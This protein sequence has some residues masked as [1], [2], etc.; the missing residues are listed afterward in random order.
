[1][2]FFKKQKNTQLTDKCKLIIETTLPNLLYQ[3]YDN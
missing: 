3:D 2:E 1:M